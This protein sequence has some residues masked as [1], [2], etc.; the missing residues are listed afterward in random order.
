V[1][2]GELALL[3]LLLGLVLLGLLAVAGLGFA[4][5][6]FGGGWV[7]PAGNTALVH[8]L[9]GLATG[10]PG[11][12]L[13]PVA[14]AQLP[15]RLAIYGCVAA[16]ELLA[17]AVLVTAGVAV[18]RRYRSPS[19]PA[20]GMANRGEAVAALGLARLRGSRRIIR[21]DL[22]PASNEQTNTPAASRPPAE[23]GVFLGKSSDTDTTEQTRWVR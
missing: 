22:Y 1:H 16:C 18:A 23:R 6:V 7:W 8:T 2:S 4:A 15:G 20:S 19:D 13:S 10:R 5:A 3:A 11:T 17:L 14:A 9:V 21:P 12:G